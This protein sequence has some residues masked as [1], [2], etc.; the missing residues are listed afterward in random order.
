MVLTHMASSLDYAT[1][2]DELPEGVEPGFD[3]MELR[4]A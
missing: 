4:V 1:L 2:R 3:G